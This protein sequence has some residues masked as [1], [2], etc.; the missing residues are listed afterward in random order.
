MPTMR[1]PS[2]NKL[3]WAAW[4]CW[5]PALAGAQE[6]PAAVPAIPANGGNQAIAPP[7][8]FASSGDPLIDALTCRSGTTDILGL[9]PRLRRDRPEDFVQTERQYS[10]P[11]MDLY[12]LESPVQAWGQHSDA[13]VITANRVLMVVDGSTDEVAQ[14]LEENLAQT[15]SAPLP[16]ALDDQHALVLYAEQRPGLSQ[17]VLIGCEYRLPDLSLLDD[18][19]DAWRKPPVAVPSP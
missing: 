10:D 6:R 4:L 11:A 9:L 8:E 19:Q 13:I 5:V 18:P 3:R 17:R 2:S 7:I 12:R 14:A 16:G 1:T 15:E